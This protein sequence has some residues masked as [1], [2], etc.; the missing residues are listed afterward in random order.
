MYFSSRSRL[1][2]LSGAL[3]A[4]LLAA[5]A[6]PAAA[7]P[8]EDHDTRHLLFVTSAQENRERTEVTYPLHKGTSNGK[9]VWYVITDTSDRGL[10]ALLGVNYA[11]KL[12][13]AKGTAAVQ[14]VAV[15]GFVGIVDFPASVD[16]SPQHVIVPGP[17]GFPP[18]QAQPG[19]VGET[20]NGVAYSPL[21]QLADGV[22]V[23]APQIAN[24]TGRADKVIRLDVD[25][26]T[27]TYVETTGF[28]DGT[29]VHYASFESSSP[30]AAAIEDVTY[31]PSL[32][33]AP[34]PGDES[35]ST[36]AR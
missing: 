24:A 21:I 23:N 1:V 26:M 28:Y 12:A 15:D 20:V 11:P 34:A 4:L 29:P 27:V 2:A 10:S 9:D 16:F 35:D 5:P 36:S 3:S 19:A 22:I 13:N 17:T 25:D 18:A 6:L 7:N 8:L 14:N 30:V 31:A 33:A 32:N